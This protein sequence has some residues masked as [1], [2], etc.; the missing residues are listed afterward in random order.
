M[1]V[2]SSVGLKKECSAFICSV[3]PG[4]DDLGGH[5]PLTLVDSLCVGM[6]VGQEEALANRGIEVAFAGH[7]VCAFDEIPAE[8][9]CVCVSSFVSGLVQRRALQ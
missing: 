2:W 3:V 5:L 6:E 1:L 8:A 7:L 4:V 9:A